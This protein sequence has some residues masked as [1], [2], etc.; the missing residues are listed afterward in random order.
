MNSPWDDIG[1][2]PHYAAYLAMTKPKDNGEKVPELDNYAYEPINLYQTRLLK[3]NDNDSDPNCPITC[4]LHVANLLDPAFDGLGLRAREGDGDTDLLVTYDALSYT[5]GDNEQSKTI[6]CNKKPLSVTSNLFSALVAL[7]SGSRYLWVDAI[8]VEQQNDEEKGFQVRNMLLIYQ[9][10]TRVIAWLGEA[11]PLARS[12]LNAVND[13]A[14]YP[15]GTNKTTDIHLDVDQACTALQNLYMK[16]WYRRIWVQQEIF[17]ARSLVFQWG[18]HTFSWSW[19]LSA[20]ETWLKNHPTL[21]TLRARIV[22]HAKNELEKQSST[23]GEHDIHNFSDPIAAIQELH[24]KRL[25]CFEHFRQGT[26][27]TGTMDR[28]STFTKTLLRTSVL[29]A[30][31][32]RDYIY[33]VLGM[34]GFPA[35]PM[36]I[37]EWIIAREAADTPFIRQITLLTTALFCVL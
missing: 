10:A 17:A 9:R 6:L 34:T 11:H 30:S 33:A 19:P 35:R 15:M 22:A 28:P 20:P 3:I 24:D 12:L 31:N 21:K 18:S 32:P 16:P 8:C 7:R 5:W 37:K 25:S 13:S 14:R 36:K 4:T 1:R 2:W 29:E 23:H 26:N 27:S